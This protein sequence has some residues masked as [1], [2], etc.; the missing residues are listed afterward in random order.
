M[1]Y[2]LA[3]TV[4]R[5]VCVILIPLPVS[6]V[7]AKSVEVIF[8]QWW[9]RAI[10]LLLAFYWVIPFTVMD[11][12]YFLWAY[13]TLLVACVCLPYGIFVHLASLLLRRAKWEK[14]PASISQ[15]APRCGLRNLVVRG[16]AW[17]LIVV[18]PALAL[19]VYWRLLYSSP[20]MDHSPR[21]WWDRFFLRPVVLWTPFALGT[22][23]L[24]RLIL[25]Y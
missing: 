17:C 4:G 12:P 20:W 16:G 7:L 14:A 5:L 1:A 19:L 10:D 3:A 23:A 15:R 18:L 25:R 22:L 11:D 2:Q 6:L 8:P 21:E 13:Y 9:G 24:R